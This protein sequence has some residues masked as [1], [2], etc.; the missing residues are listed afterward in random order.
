[1]LVALGREIYEEVGLKIFVVK[2]E[3]AD[4]LHYDFP[5][6]DGV[7][8][9]TAQGIIGQRKKIFLVVCADNVVFDFNTHNTPE[10]VSYK[11]VTP[12]ECVLQAVDFKQAMYASALKEFGL[13]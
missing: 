8:H 5:N 9:L 6:T 12:T 2:A 11:L 4:F 3:T 1:L 7:E 13:L 10:F